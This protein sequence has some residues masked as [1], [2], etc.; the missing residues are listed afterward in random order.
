MK[1][2]VAAGLVM[3][4]GLAAHPADARVFWGLGRPEAG[5]IPA[6]DVSYRRAYTAELT[7]NQGKGR[8]EV[9]G[10]AREPESVLQDLQ[11]K[12][13]AEGGRIMAASGGA[14]AWALAVTADGRI[15]RLLV[16]AAEGRY[17]HVFQL[18][19]DED[20]YRRS[21]TPPDQV[22]LDVPAVPG[23][24]VTSYLANDA[25]GTALASLVS[26][27]DPVALRQP[28]AEQLAAAGWERLPAGGGDG[29]VFVRGGTLL[30]VSVK[31]AGA[32]GGAL[33]TLAHKR[34]K[35]SERP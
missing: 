32:D 16:S 25:S 28:L 21:L 23:A 26:D 10:T 35:A 22:P 33:V 3:L 5:L 6:T 24:R 9:W 31:R 14:L 13:R 18:S 34:L 20:D 12:A 27:G 15:H 19:Q 7:I 1:R 30:L 8:L 11:A 2:H 29:A 4:L 17:C